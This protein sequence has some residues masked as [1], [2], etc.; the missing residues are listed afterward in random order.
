[1][2]RQTKSVLMRSNERERLRVA[3]TVTQSASGRR[4]SPIKGSA[5]CLSSCC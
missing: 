2:S 4:T 1:M 5:A 3:A